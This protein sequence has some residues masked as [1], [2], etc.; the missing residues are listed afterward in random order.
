MGDE[1]DDNVRYVRGWAEAAPF[2]R[3]L[4]IAV[5]DVTPGRVRLRMDVDE[6]HLNG[7]GIVHG[8]VLPALADA[9]MGS[10]ARTVHGE[11]AQMLTA[12]SNIRYLRAIDGDGGAIVAQARIVKSGRRVTF[13]EVDVADASGEIVAR[14]GAT[15]VIQMKE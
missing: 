11:R 8:G 6:R 4:G 2:Y 5:E 14:G 9:A 12:E 15:F 13:V 7:D 3:T 10:A 1:V